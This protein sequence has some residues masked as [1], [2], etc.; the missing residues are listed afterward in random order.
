M[1]APASILQAH[2][3]AFEGG[4]VF[5]VLPELNQDRARLPSFQV[6]SVCPPAAVAREPLV[7]PSPIVRESRA[8][9]S[10]EDMEALRVGRE[11]LRGSRKGAKEK[12]KGGETWLTEIREIKKACTA[13]RTAKKIHRLLLRAYPSASEISQKTV[14]RRMKCI[15]EEEKSANRARAPH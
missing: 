12:R 11:V 5:D 8:A 9:L 3:G 2:S 13:P 14:E 15:E 6:L 4:A 10:E 7:P 1:S